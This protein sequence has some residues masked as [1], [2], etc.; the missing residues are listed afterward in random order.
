RMLHVRLGRCFDFFLSAESGAAR[1]SH[2]RRLASAPSHPAFVRR[3]KGTEGNNAR[4]HHEC[5]HRRQNNSGERCVTRIY[6][7]RY[8]KQR[9]TPFRREAWRMI[10]CPGG[11]CH[12]REPGSKK[13]ESGDRRQETGEK[14]T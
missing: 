12:R 13:Q 10:D 7:A 14:K 6:V 4:E 11:F 8:Q 9:K 5:Q 1:A 3:S 2:V